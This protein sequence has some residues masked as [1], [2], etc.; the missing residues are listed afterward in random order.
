VI[1]ESLLGFRIEGGDTLVLEPRLP[2]DWPG[3]TLRYR[4]GNAFYTVS[5]EHA[6]EEEDFHGDVDGEALEVEGGTARLR[7]HADVHSHAVALR[8]PRTTQ[9]AE[10]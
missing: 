1:V 7:L 4:H 10:S 6:D 2:A 9:P 8:V 5:V 3:F